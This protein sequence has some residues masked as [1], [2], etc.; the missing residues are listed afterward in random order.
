M[1]RVTQDFFSY[2]ELILTGLAG[3]YFGYILSK[4]YGLEF[5]SYLEKNVP[6]CISLDELHLFIV[7]NFFKIVDSIGLD[8]KAKDYSN[9][10][11]EKGYR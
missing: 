9:Y 5:F 11:E 8:F 3:D 4:D 1:I 6:E 2:E 10:L 7:S